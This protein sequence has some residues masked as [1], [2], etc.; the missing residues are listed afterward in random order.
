MMIPSVVDHTCTMLSTGAKS[1][2]GTI[3]DDIVGSPVFQ[4]EDAQKRCAAE[5]A[6][7]VVVAEADTGKSSLH[8]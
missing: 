8:V 1:T 2:D 7:N 6:G 5:S 3:A 4:A